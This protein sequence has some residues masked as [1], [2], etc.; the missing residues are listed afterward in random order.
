VFT[1]PTTG[2]ILSHMLPV[3]NFQPIFPKIHSNIILPFVPRAQR[4]DGPTVSCKVTLTLTLTKVQ[5]GLTFQA[6]TCIKEKS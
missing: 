3:H 2:P 1:E 5:F 6:Y 4:Q